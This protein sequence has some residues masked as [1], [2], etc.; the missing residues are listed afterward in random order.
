[1]SFIA[2]LLPK[3]K[4]ARKT[5]VLPEGD[6][7]RVMQAAAQ[8][9]GQEIASVRVLATP[10]DARAAAAGVCFDGLDVTLVDHLAS[11]QAEPL[12]VALQRRRAHK[13][14]TL[15]QA[16]EKI[17]DRLYF[18]NM[19][20]CE[21]AV[22]GL[23]AGSLASTAS[24]VRSAF[25]CIGTA[26]GIKAASSC[27][28][29]DLT[30]PT[31][32]GEGLLIYADC[33]VNPD[34]TAEQLADIAIA[35]IATRRAL[36][37]DMPRIAFLSFST[38]GSAKHPLVDK[39]AHATAL[40]RARVSEIGLEATIDGEIQGD[41]AIV[42]DIA[43]RKCP[44]SPLAGRANILI[45]PDLQAGNICYKITERLA[46]AAAYGPV[47]QGLAKPVNDLSRGC[48]VADIVGVA[49]ITVCQAIE[50]ENAS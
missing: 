46:G 19:L 20:L 29:M 14:M 49:A 28:V 45:F 9:A 33:G 21:G 34:P 42:P 38:R 16:R 37:G 50:R 24:M 13:G 48:S 47:L 22:D 25:H 5:I 12:A 30:H 41:A 11:P 31:P 3:S 4:R 8:I 26:P 6:D 15:D 32:G 36:V 40:T 23:V 1:M 17:R 27:L 2:T 43:A 10:E 39:V 18:G 35:T 7:P 44:E